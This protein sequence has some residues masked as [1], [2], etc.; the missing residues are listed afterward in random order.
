VKR[1]GL[2]L[3]AVL[4]AGGAAAIAAPDAVGAESDLR[5][6]SDARYDVLPDE[7]LVRVT[8]DLTIRYAR[9]ETRARRYYV[10]AA[11]LA[12]L[13]GTR[14]FRVTGDGGPRVRVSRE[15]ATHTLLR[16][17][18]GQRLYGGGTRKLRLRF[19]LPDPG[20]A[21]TRE[22]RVGEALVAFPV[23]SFAS[24]GAGPSTV[25]V[26][27]PPGFEIEVGSGPLPD[28]STTEDGRQ[29]L[30]SG[31]VATPA[32]FFAYVVGEAPGAYTETRLPF[33]IAGERVSVVL[34]AWKDDP[35]WAER[36]RAVLEGGI[37][38]L[39]ERIGLPW[40]AANPLV[41]E[42]TTSR[43][44]TALAARY[45][46]DEGRLELAYY[47]EPRVVL[48]QAA[49]A[50]FD[51]ELLAD[52]WATEGFAALYAREVAASMD[53]SV[54]PADLP[55]DLR[56]A[57]TP[58]NAWAPQARPETEAAGLAA[59]L[60]LARLVRQ[61]AGDA[62]LRDVWADAA[63]RVGAYQ[64]PPAT[65]AGRAGESAGV[66][67]D[68]EPERSPGPPD[69]RGLL[70]LLEE[71]TGQAFDDLWRGWVV[72]PREAAL[73][74]ARA[75]AR[76]S[77]RR[78][79]ALADGWAI[80]RGVRD[81]L[82]AWRFEVAQ[83]YL[84]DL[85]AVIAQREALEVAADRAGLTLPTTVREAF[86]AGRLA[87][88][89]AVA[90]EQLATV[91]VIVSAAASRPLDPDPVTRLGLL[92][93]R[94]DVELAA[95]RAAFASGDVEAARRSA[96]AAQDT[97]DRAWDLGRRRILIGLAAAVAILLGLGLAVAGLRRRRGMSRRPLEPTAPVQ[98]P[99]TPAG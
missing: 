18:L 27:V 9:A 86:E 67:S 31:P 4:L 95:A 54:P 48:E 19:D 76:A 49:H 36:I 66:A 44:T 61:R 55:E 60:E 24:D 98:P 29:V 16:I 28:R 45:E 41:V 65:G 92:D 39:A 1:I 64:P 15:L 11:L 94:P 85:R 37:P 42:E 33:A 20:G 46:P 7:A 74:D 58:L 3:A 35:A 93:Q 63:D 17:D 40:P 78:T 89:S 53:V 52:R 80:P 32:T 23:W 34:R 69:W 38:R 96:G 73:L 5:I 99:P 14:G 25:T 50:W 10:D 21:P 51:G 43:S 22:L 72:R 70:D 68:P 26:V 77:Y 13:P 88:S 82:R 12:V 81:A 56:A 87:E 97:W 91:D 62:A 2:L 47:A 90:A 79:L 83:A 71:R 84:E 75:D 59:A 57:A 6:T 8:V 30:R